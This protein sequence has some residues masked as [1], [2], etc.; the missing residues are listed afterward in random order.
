MTI[1]PSNSQPGNTYQSKKMELKTEDFIKMMI[2][3]LQHQDPLEPAKNEALLAQMAQIGQMQSSTALQDMLKGL[4]SQ[5]Q[6][7][8]AGQLMGK[9]VAGL[10]E[11]DQAVQGQVTS[12]RVEKDQV[13]LE[14]DTG[15][16]VAL[17]RVT[18]IAPPPAAK[19]A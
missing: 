18:T 2:T 12:V 14:L 1:Q 19:A 9:M 5:N 16:R 10:D 6:I 3:Q 11:H 15:K 4:A 17:G 7:G 13:F 8:A